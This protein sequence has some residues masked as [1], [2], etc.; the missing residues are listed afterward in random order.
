MEIIR[1]K[2]VGRKFQNYIHPE[3]I[4]QSKNVVGS[5]LSRDEDFW[6]LKDINLNVNR[7][8]IIGVIGRNGS[9]KTTLLRIIS[10]RLNPTEGDVFVDGEVSYLISLGA[11]FQA[12]LT[13]KENIYLNAALL[14]MDRSEIDA[15]FMDIVEFS[16]LGDFIHA[17]VG[18]YSAG[19]KMRLGFSI[20]I[21]KDF[22]V[23]VTDEVITVGDRYFQNKCLSKMMDF[24]RQGKSM[25]IVSQNLETIE[26]FCDRVFLLEEGRIFAHGPA[27]EVIEQYKMLLNKRKVLSEDFSSHMVS[28]T[29]RWATDMPEWGK[30]E[31][32]KE[33]T[34]DNVS[35]LNSW[36]MR[37][38]VFRPREKI[39]IRADFTANEE[40]RDFHFGVAIFREDGV[41]CYGPNT[42][43]D[44]LEIG[45]M[46]KGK[47]HFKFV[48]NELLLMPG[49]YYLSVAVWDKKENFAYDYHK[50]KYS[51]EVKG[52]PSCGELL[53][54]AHEWY[55]D[56]YFSGPKDA[57]C[58]CLDSLIE[59]WGTSC[60]DG[61]A[62]VAEVICLN[63]Y[64]GKDSVFVT[65]RDLKIKVDFRVDKSFE[66]RLGS[67]FL[68]VGIYRSDGIYCHGSAKR[69]FF[70][71]KRTATVFYPK[72]RLL[73]GGYR[74]SAGIWDSQVG[75][76]LAYSHGNHQ[77]NMVS[78]RKDHGS[79]Y[80]DHTWSWKVPK[81]EQ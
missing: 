5:E 34:I 17:P 65:G 74:I 69:I 4:H 3:G 67:L 46:G 71:D 9:G 7:G 49:M 18:S 63:N 19:M 1:L 28:E 55:K 72:I 10:G 25:L 76:F 73:P 61:P 2:N 78:E 64:G 51:F 66:K 35:F 21:H 62:S 13:G 56:T 16:E 38:G 26:R 57:Q 22:D 44:C 24:K 31:G 23:L 30:T 40:L 80:L 58:P 37:K 27:G 75:S 54:L 47:G 12:A 42:S 14:G 52:V 81:K 8:E 50:C 32:S 33:V 59:K 15:K 36:G 39:V 48:C 11:G 43:L 29:K 45:S 68:W 41:Y 6:A 77:F 53:I 20:S 70:S 79:V 60:G